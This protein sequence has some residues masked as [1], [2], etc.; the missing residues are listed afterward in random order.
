MG[1]DIA[2]QECVILVVYVGACCLNGGVKGAVSP[3]FFSLYLACR[4]SIER[5]HPTPIHGL[6]LP[7]FACLTII[8]TSCSTGEAPPK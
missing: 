7:P 3:A 1:R 4:E 8:A 6:P 5:G 2:C